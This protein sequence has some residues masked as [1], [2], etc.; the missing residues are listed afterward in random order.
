MKAKMIINPERVGIRVIVTEVT[1]E[2]KEQVKERA[3]KLIDK[4]G[5]PQYRVFSIQPNYGHQGEYVAVAMVP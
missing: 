3:Q 5:F 2:T 1:D 4:R